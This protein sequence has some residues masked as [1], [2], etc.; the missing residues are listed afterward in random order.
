[1]SSVGLT[2]RSTICYP[3]FTASKLVAT[4]VFMDFT[5]L[6]DFMLVFAFSLKFVPLCKNKKKTFITPP[7]QIQTLLCDRL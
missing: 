6:F 2:Y 7:K 4:S 3:N 1:M 5:Y